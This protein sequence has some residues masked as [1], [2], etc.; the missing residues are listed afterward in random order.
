[1]R[2]YGKRGPEDSAV[3]ACVLA[4][5][6]AGTTVPTGD[7]LI[8]YACTAW[9]LLANQR[10]MT[11]LED[12][13][14]GSLPADRNR[15]LWR[16]LV[17]PPAAVENLRV[18]PDPRRFLW[19]LPKPTIGTAIMRERGGGAW[20]D[21]SLSPSHSLVDNDAFVIADS[22][23]PACRFYSGNLSLIGKSAKL[24]HRAAERSLPRP[25]T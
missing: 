11:N 19:R 14:H 15:N 22:G 9:G 1:V 10:C 2:V 8:P 18:D 21:L 5:S 17:R 7:G 20:L 24:R 6:S 25:K 16:Q 4:G 3:R 12:G 13:D 23:M